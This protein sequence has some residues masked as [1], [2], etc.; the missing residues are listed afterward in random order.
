MSRHVRNSLQAP[1]L[2]LIALLA[3]PAPAL[4]KHWQARP[5][6]VRVLATAVLAMLTVLLLLALLRTTTVPLARW[7][8]H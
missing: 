3:T 7:V 4:S 2:F 6:P 8:W 5:A 1:L